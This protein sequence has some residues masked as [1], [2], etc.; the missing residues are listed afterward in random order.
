ML[1][2]GGDLVPGLLAFAAFALSMIAAVIAIDMY[3]L[4]RTG[5]SGKV[6]RVLI[7]ASVLFAL[8]QVLRFAEAVQWQGWSQRYALSQ[9]AELVYVTALVYAF[10][11]QRQAFKA[12][13][14]LRSHELEPE[15]ELSLD[16]EEPESEASSQ[17]SWDLLSTRYAEGDAA[18]PPT[19]NR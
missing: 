18:K 16:V 19:L 14:K 4:L 1:D 12:L 9:V 8:A 15:P 10:Y 6:W 7:I 11:M 17:P 5:E 13:A 3:T 2:H